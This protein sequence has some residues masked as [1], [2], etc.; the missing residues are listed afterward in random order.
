[1]DTAFTT[2]TAGCCPLDCPDSCAWTVH[3]EGAR[4]TKV[5]GVKTHPITRGV[6]CAKLRDYEQRLV[7]PDR[8]LHPMRRAGAKGEGRFE[9]ISWDTAL[10]EIT[11]RFQGIIAEHGAE[12]LYPFFYIGSMGIV[13]RYALMRVFH[14]LGASLP[15]GN[16]CAQSAGVLAEEGHPIGLDPEDIPKAEL[17]ILW[18]NN[19]LSTG[20]H[21]WPFIDEARKSGAKVIAIDP[22][23]TRTAAAADQHLKIR[24]GTDAIL[25]AAMAQV[26]ISEGL[27]DLDSF[28]AAAADF[29]AYEQAVMEWTPERA[30]S[31]TGIAAA[32][33]RELARAFGKAKPAHIRAGVAPMQTADGEAFVRALS[34]LAFLGGHWQRPGG[35]LALLSIPEVP[36]ARAG[37][38]DL[39]KGTP[40]T[41]DMARLGEIL[42]P[43]AMARPVKGLMV[44]SANPAV[45]QI[46]TPRVRKGLLR[47]DLFTVVFDHFI[48]DTARYADIVLP[49]TT[50]FEHFD[51]QGAWGHYYVSLNKPAVAPMG[52]A[53]SGGELMRRLAAKLGLDD[54][55]FAESDETIAAAALPEGWSMDELK[56]AGWKKLPPQ[57]MQLKATLRFSAGPIMA[58]AVQPPGTLQLLTPKSHYFLNSTFANMPR[59]RQSQGIPSIELHAEDARRQGLN[60]GDWVIVKSPAASLRIT[61]KVSEDAMPGI[62]VM[63]GKWWGGEEETSGQ[64]NRLSPSS[65]SPGGQPAYN[66]TYVTV[67]RT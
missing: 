12:A 56:A 13:Q 31:I 7:A 5:E 60:E 54:P 64:M 11:A 10:T 8:L 49:A 36:E 47:D 44:W 6:L 21:V 39:A 14:A 51:M 61:L 25:A 16:V 46:D 53:V 58:P 3:T 42:D 66:E 48:T 62:A 22:R 29:E 57:P 30:A 15:V 2:K 19:L 27:A 55:A 45:T 52:E 28:K 26:M 43:S 65:W 1:M 63:Q 32:D 40:R 9:R 17:I 50:Q 67:E 37:R 33:I 24:P 34:A 23:R 4:V 59:Q 20:H 18:G 38:P 41:L 35:G